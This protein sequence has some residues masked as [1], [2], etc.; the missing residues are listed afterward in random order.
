M[1][2]FCYGSPRLHPEPGSAR[3]VADYLAGYGEALADSQS[4]CAPDQMAED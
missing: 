3:A 1:A 4:D 2:K